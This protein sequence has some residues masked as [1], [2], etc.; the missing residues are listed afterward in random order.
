[1]NHVQKYLAQANRQ[2]A[3]LMVQIVR[4]RAIVKHALDTG[5]RSEMAESM[6]NALEAKPSL[7]REAPDI[8]AQLQRI[9]SPLA[10]SGS[11]V[12]PN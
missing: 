1:M 6:L 9:I 10:M 3:E 11:G 8:F 5:P 4:Q 12:E 2:I 7:I